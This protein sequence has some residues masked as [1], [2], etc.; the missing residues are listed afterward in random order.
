V[1][2]EELALHQ[3]LAEVSGPDAA[4]VGLGWIAGQQGDDATALAYF[5][6]ALAIRRGKVEKWMVAET[7]NLMGEV[8]QRQGKLEQAYKYYTEGLVLAHEVG[9]KAAIAYLFLHLGTLA[10]TQN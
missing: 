9:D 6:Q 1:F 7:L 3:S 2:E 4:F 8:F 5:E 10:H